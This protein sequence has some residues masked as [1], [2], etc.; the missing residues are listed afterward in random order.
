MP[1]APPGCCATP[2]RSPINAGWIRNGQGPAPAGG[3]GSIASG[4]TA[5]PLIK[6]TQHCEA[7]I[8]RRFPPGTG[9][10]DCTFFQGT[11]EKTGTLLFGCSAP[12]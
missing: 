7:G 11:Q 8:G 2:R 3:A 6:L 5:G 12:G 10:V 9:C 4:N 1:P